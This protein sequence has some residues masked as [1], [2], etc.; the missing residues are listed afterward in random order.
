M[1]SKPIRILGFVSLPLIYEKRAHIKVLM[2]KIYFN[3]HTSQLNSLNCDH[4]TEEI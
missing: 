4:S 1:I 3:L 2:Q